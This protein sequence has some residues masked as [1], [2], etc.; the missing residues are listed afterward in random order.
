MNNLT[1]MLETI[2]EMDQY[3]YDNRVAEWRRVETPSGVLEA[4]P[5]EQVD[6]WLS[7]P[8][9]SWAQVYSNPNWN[10]PG[11]RASDLSH[12]HMVTRGSNRNKDFVDQSLY[13][14]VLEGGQGRGG[15]YNEILWDLQREGYLDNA[16][17][18]SEAGVQL[19][20]EIYNE[21]VRQDS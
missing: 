6:Y 16:G 21:F 12:F 1:N 9:L 20:K 2:D 10:G 7:R 4:V 19:R 14:F 18:L 3:T 13:F 17:L 8:A 5:N 15:V 11:R